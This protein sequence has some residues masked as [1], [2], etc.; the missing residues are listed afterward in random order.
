VIL[1]AGAANTSTDSIA[2]HRFSAPGVYSIKLKVTEER[3]CVDSITMTNYIEARGPIVNFINDQAQICS[4]TTV[5]FTDKSSKT[6]TDTANPLLNTYLWNFG[7]GSTSTLQNPTH[8]FVGAGNYTVKLEVTDNNGCTNE[9]SITNSV[10]VPPVL[11]GFSTTRDSYCTDNSTLIS[12]TSTAVGTITSYDWDMDGDGI[13][14]IINGTANQTRT[15]P[16]KGVYTIRQR[17]TSNLGCQNSFTKNI[18]IVDGTGGIVLADPYLGCAP[19]TAVLLPADSASVVS[20]YLWDFGDGKTS[21]LRNPT[22]DYLKPGKYSLTLTEVLTGGCSKSSTVVVEVGGALGAF[23]YNTAPSCTPYTVTLRADNLAG[24]GSLIWDFGDGSTFTEK[25]A[26]GV[27]SKT[28]SHTYNSSGS[29]L[30]ILI[31]KDSVCGNSVSLFDLTKRINTSEPPVAAF[32]ASTINGQSCE[33]YILQFTDSSTLKDIRYPIAS[34]DWDFGD[35]SHSALQN[36]KHSFA[37]PGNYT[38]KLSISN[39]FI[40]GGCNSTVSKNIGVNPLPVVTI[41]NDDQEIYTNTSTL[42]MTLSS[43]I[44][45]TTFNWSR[46][47]PTGVVTNLPLNATNIPNGGTIPSALFTNST[48]SPIT[49]NYKIVP[50]GPAPT[51]C[52]GDTL[53]TTLIVDPIPSVSITKSASKPTMNNDGSYSWRYTISIINNINQKLDSIRVIDN[54]DD[55]FKPQNCDYKVTGISA[56]G[57]LTANGLFNGSSNTETLVEGLTLGALKHDSIIVEVR[58]DTHGQKDTLTVFNQALLSCKSTMKGF[59]I[60]SDANAY[61]VQ[62]E[63]TQTLIPMVELFIPDAFSPNHDGINE[64]F[65]IAHAETMR[66]ELEIFNRWGNSVYKSVDYKNDWDGKGTGKVLGQDLPSG[67]YYINYKM[68]KLSTGETIS[69]GVKYIT[70]KKE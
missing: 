37:T 24:V 43:A 45:G 67:T 38:V 13:F 19:A 53:N 40:T 57:S 10:I 5:T 63:K 62:Y 66:V 59:S 28:I 1:P 35:G 52:V 55:V 11:A 25:V 7:D 8:T 4:G 33:K 32:G 41:S 20:S 31:L 61:T 58:V 14:E 70:L 50:I 17:V 30:P 69:S 54:L 6:T 15:F 29:K 23:S 51:L 9:K 46:T 44:T 21:T 42:P 2:K 48:I 68:T 60:L 12:F 3:A 47:S 26:K 18:T 34:W 27:N 49:V 22:H 36:P 56:S 64:H 65:I 39:N 16:T